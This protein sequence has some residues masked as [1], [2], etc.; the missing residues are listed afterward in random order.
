MYEA[1]IKAEDTFIMK[2]GEI[3]HI[4]IICTTEEDGYL[5]TTYTVFDT[6]WRKFYVPEK[7]L[8]CGIKEKV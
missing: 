4:D 8:R 5:F 1:E 6:Q 7:M 2:W 3:Y